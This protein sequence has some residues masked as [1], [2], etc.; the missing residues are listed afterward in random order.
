MH[1]HSSLFLTT[2]TINITTVV[3]VNEFVLII[4]V[5]LQMV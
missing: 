2:T 1:L 3:V 4:N 5:N